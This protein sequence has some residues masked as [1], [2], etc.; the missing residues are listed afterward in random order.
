MFAD[1][2]LTGGNI[3]NAMFL[4]NVFTD[5]GFV[6]AGGNIQMTCFTECVN[7]PWHVSTGGNIQMPY[8]KKR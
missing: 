5:P 4:Q 7:S 3:H 8:F 2:L 1:C 6:S